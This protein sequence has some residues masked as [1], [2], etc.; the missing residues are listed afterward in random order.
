MREDGL[1]PLRR[2]T[3]EA[4]KRSPGKGWQ[5]LAVLLRNAAPKVLELLNKRLAGS[6]Q[7]S[8]ISQPERDSGAVGVSHCET[9]EGPHGTRGP[10]HSPISGSPH[11]NSSD[12]RN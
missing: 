3:R 7:R 4:P 2:Y 12:N 11:L 5:T 9:D 10:V 8:A 1:L 6:R